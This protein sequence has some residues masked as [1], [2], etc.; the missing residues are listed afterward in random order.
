VPAADIST[1]ARQLPD[2]YGFRPPNLARFYLDRGSRMFRVPQ[3]YGID[4]ESLDA[5]WPNFLPKRI[6]RAAITQFVPYRELSECNSDAWGQLDSAVKTWNLR[7][8]T[9]RKMG[10]HSPLT[11]RD[12]GSFVRITDVRGPEPKSVTLKGD[13]RRLFLACGRKTLVEKLSNEMQG[14]KAADF[15]AALRE[16]CSHKLVIVEAGQI[17]ALPVRFRTP[18]PSARVTRHLAGVFTN[19]T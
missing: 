3:N 15:D 16:L 6:A 8:E 5:A 12:G 4:P 17:L 14:M 18:I 13:L 7:Y 19:S 2:L 1:M 10:L 11:F 9:A